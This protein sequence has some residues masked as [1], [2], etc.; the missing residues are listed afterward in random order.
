MTEDTL[1][2]RLVDT[3]LAMNAQGINGGRDGNVSV[4][5]DGGFLIT[6]SGI[7]FPALQDAD[8]CKM[9]LAGESFGERTP[10]SEWLFHRDIYAN[11]LDAEAIVHTHSTYASAL[12]CLGKGIPSFHYM[13]ALAG[14]KDIRC[15]AYATYGS[16]K[17]SDIAV[18]ALR[19]R[20]ACLL[21][22]H[23]VITLGDSLER[24]LELAYEVEQLAKMYMIVLQTGGE[25]LLLPD[26][27]MKR[28]ALKL[29]AHGQPQPAQPTPLLR[30]VA[31]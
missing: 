18:Q 23:G 15:T 26:D 3:C 7:D 2:H 30:A 25:P 28:V 1:R 11:R 22:Q 21:G 27:E 12:S 17:L 31:R 6:P 10:S 14:G 9:N 24:A 16:Q 8:L 5:C 4:R 13:V 29:E 19:E 20:K